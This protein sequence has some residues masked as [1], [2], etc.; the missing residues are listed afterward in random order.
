MTKKM[1]QKK[2]FST[3]NLGLPSAAFLHQN[4]NHRGK[5]IPNYDRNENL[6]WSVVFQDYTL[7]FWTYE[8]AVI[9]Q[10]KD[11]DE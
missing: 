9:S 8:E 3:T 6:Y 2:I 11:G 7:S 10:E 1:K 4:Q 5:I